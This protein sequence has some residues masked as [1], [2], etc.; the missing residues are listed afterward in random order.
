MVKTGQEV[1]NRRNETRGNIVA[2]ATVLRDDISGDKRI[3][4]QERGVHMRETEALEKEG[5]IGE[6]IRID[7]QDTGVEANDEGVKRETQKTTK[8]N[9]NE[10]PKKKANRQTEK[11]EMYIVEKN[12]GRRKKT[13]EIAD[14]KQRRSP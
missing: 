9:R 1:P 13:Q 6:K 10:E 4:K 8:I 5:G 11:E 2:G 14:H 7:W 12:E 3:L